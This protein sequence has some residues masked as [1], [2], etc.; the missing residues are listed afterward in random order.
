M[1]TSSLA[2]QPLTM[3]RLGD[4]DELIIAQSTS[5]CCR[6]ACFQPSINWVVAEGNNFEPG[7][8]PFAL[9][10]VAWIHEESS[11]LGRCFS[12]CA[13]G[14]RGIKYVQHSGTPPASIMGENKSYFSCQFG[15]TPVT[16]SEADAKSNVVVTH[17]KGQTCGI[18]C[19]VLPCVCNTFGLPYLETKDGSTG[20]TLGVT[21]Y[22]CDINCFVPKY[23]ILDASGNRIYHLRPNTCIAGLC[24]ECRC[25]GEKGKCCRI[26][27]I[28]RDPSTLK[29]I[30]SGATLDG[31]PVDAMVDTLWAGWK[32]EC[33]SQRNAYHVTF[34][35]DISPEQKAILMGST[36]L[37]D[38]T[39]F[40][41]TED[42]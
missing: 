17:E 3:D 13:P 42:E 10:N 30:P 33:C 27:F 2:P 31:K 34:P 7:T 5:Q 35:K 8:N 6:C 4:R 40:E 28:I 41:Q 39:V 18:G 37:V 15:E 21:Q 32:N 38:V 11:F 1:N 36:I 20:A 9:D 19:F 12:G 16:L 24:P 14:C 23:D 29:P 25:D 22:V 26:P